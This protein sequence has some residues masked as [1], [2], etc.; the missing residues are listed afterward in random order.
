M[1][2]KKNRKNNQSI[3]ITIMWFNNIFMEN[4]KGLSYDAERQINITNGLEGKH[5]FD[6]DE[7]ADDLDFNSI[8]NL[9][10]NLVD[11]KIINKKIIDK[12]KKIDKIFTNLSY[13]SKSYEEAF[14]TDDGVRNH[15]V[16]VELRKLAK[17]VVELIEDNDE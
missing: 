16:W 10:E 12:V 2:F 15:Q 17:E 14:W 11:N 4:I 6:L 8:K 1:K 7:I 3:E 13:G 5:V 9:L